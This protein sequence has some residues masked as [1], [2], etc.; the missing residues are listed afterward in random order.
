MLLN[1]LR[2]CS[3]RKSHWAFHET[4]TRQNARAATEKLKEMFITLG[5]KGKM[6]SFH[7]FTSNR[8]HC[9]RLQIITR[10]RTQYSKRI[11]QNR[12]NAWF[13]PNSCGNFTVRLRNWLYY[14]CVQIEGD[15]PAWPL[16]VI[17][18]KCTMPSVS[19]IVSINTY[20]PFYM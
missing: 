3:V 5:A 11:S 9:C 2:V 18:W 4:E 1:K 15:I 12:R 13:R 20:F 8:L 19:C 17:R 6:E 14:T 7:L 16:T 10:T